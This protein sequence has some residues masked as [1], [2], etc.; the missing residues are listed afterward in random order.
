[1]QK[2][3]GYDDAKKNAQYKGSEKIPAGAYICKVLGVRYE[4][5]DWGDQ[6]VLQID[7][8]E[9]EYAGFFKKQYENNTDENKKWKGVAKVNVPKDD[10]SEQDGWTKNSFARWTDGFEK[11]NTGYTWD[12]DE[13]KWKGKKIGV[14]FGETG[15]SIDG[16]DITY[17]E[18]RAACSVDDVKSGTYWKGYT[19]FKAR[20]GYGSNGTKSDNSQYNDFVSVPEGTDEVIP[21]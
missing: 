21:F 12:W 11:S 10:G 1:M 18:V 2:F 7:V 15:A 5:F 3:N 20:K 13:N 17:M 4:S 8:A 16:K 19:K 9:G 14:I 6:I